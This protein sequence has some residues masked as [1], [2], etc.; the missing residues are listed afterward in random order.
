MYQF[1]ST[2]HLRC[3]QL[4]I[5]FFF[6]SSRRRHTR[7]WRDWSSDVCSSDL[8]G[9]YERNRAGVLLSRMT[10]DVEALNS[11]V[12]DTI[13][14]LFQASLTLLGTIVILVVLDVELALLTFLIFPVMA[15]GSLAFRIAS[16]DAYRRT[17]ETIGA[18]TGYLQETLSGIR[19]VRSFG[20]EPRH[21]RR[22]SQLNEDN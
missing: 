7:Y 14:T 20:Q 18:I 2:Y 6:F 5:V 3:L 19:V 15:A 4:R 21:L 16:A 17:R 13:I 8:V 12:T 9:F 1:A 10:N 22:F 11:L